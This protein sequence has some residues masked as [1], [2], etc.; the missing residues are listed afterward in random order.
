MRRMAL[1]LVISVLLTSML[2]AACATPSPSPT[3]AV[4]PTATATASPTTRPVASPTPAA[5]TGA[6]QYGGTLKIRISVSP[7][8]LLPPLMPTYLYAA[9]THDSLIAIDEKGELIP[10]L[11]TDW[12]LSPD[13]KSLT[14]SLRKGVKF[15]DGTDFTAS[16]VK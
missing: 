9:A 7:R 16:A 3:S 14:L 5:T 4:T 13:N 11:A 6:P 1:G 12:K 10:W 2:L 8:G 15:H